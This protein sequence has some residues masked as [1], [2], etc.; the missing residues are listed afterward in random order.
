MRTVRISTYESPYTT[1]YGGGTAAP[2]YTPTMTRNRN[3]G[4]LVV[5]TGLNL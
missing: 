1:G 3:Y 5:L 4:M 2:T